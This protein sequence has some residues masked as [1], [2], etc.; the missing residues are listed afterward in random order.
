MAVDNVSIKKRLKV[1]GW[2]DLGPDHPGLYVKDEIVRLDDV[3]SS[4]STVADMR[5]QLD[6]LEAE[7]AKSNR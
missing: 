1:T 5:R 2:V 6:E 3:T 7:F 4:G